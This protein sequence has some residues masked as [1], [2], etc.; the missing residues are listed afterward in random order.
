VVFHCPERKAAIFRG[1]VIANAS[2]FRC[3]GPWKTILISNYRQKYSSCIRPTIIQRRFGIVL[4]F[5]FCTWS[6]FPPP[7]TG[8]SPPLRWAENPPAD[9][10]LPCHVPNN[11]LANLC[12]ASERGAGI[13][14]GLGMHLINCQ[15]MATSLWAYLMKMLPNGFHELC[16]CAGRGRGGLILT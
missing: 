3:F 12:Y 7:S 11:L 13:L 16:V 10:L 15:G 9:S 8:V 2:K 14:E 1:R 6:N 4:V 5:G